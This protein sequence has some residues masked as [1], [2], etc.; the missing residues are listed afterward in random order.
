M[1]ISV[2]TKTNQNLNLWFGWT[3]ESELDLSH[4]VRDGVEPSAVTTLLKHGYDKQEL[5]WVIPSRTLSHRV[6]KSEKLTQDESAKV[7]R[8]AR[9]IAKATAVFNDAQKANNWLSK[10]KKALDGLT[11]KQAMQD[12]FGA[13]MVEQMLL[14]LESGYF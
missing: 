10:P 8:A 11:P 1:S 6:N 12:E 5:S 9:L 3:I 14:R 4:L 2:E 7:I 13:S